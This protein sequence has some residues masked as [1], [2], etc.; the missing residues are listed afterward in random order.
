MIKGVSKI[1]FVSEGFQAILTSSGTASLVSSAAKKIQAE[2]NS[3]IKGDSSGFGLMEKTA[4]A[5]GEPR[6]IALV[7]TTDQASGEAEAEEKALSGA[8]HP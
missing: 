1:E 6:A 3:K 5:Y 4:Q 8:V 2:A 7:Y